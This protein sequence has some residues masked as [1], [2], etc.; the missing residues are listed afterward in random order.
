[1]KFK[2]NFNDTV[3]IIDTKTYTK[4]V[5]IYADKLTTIYLF[6]NGLYYFEGLRLPCLQPLYFKTQVQAPQSKS[7]GFN[8]ETA[9]G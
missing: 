6:G 7:A 3:N 5:K 9:G 4:I 2:F 8:H 1:M